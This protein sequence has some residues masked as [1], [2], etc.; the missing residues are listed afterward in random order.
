MKRSRNKAT[1]PICHIN[2]VIS[3]LAASAHQKSLTLVAERNGDLRVRWHGWA[4]VGYGVLVKGPVGCRGTALAA[5]RTGENENELRSL[6]QICE[7]HQEKRFL[8]KN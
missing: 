3:R 2:R 4:A 7:S 6:L 1:S 8:L 5:E